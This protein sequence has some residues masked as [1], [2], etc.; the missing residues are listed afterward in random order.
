L[1]SFAVERRKREMGAKVHPGPPRE[2]PREK[3]GVQ[4]ATRGSKG[5]VTVDAI[6]SG[7]P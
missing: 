5:R 2:S 6:K 1:E 4:Q 7:S 3:S